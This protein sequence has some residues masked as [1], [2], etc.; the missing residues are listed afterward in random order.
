MIVLAFDTAM[1]GCSAALYD[2]EG[3]RVLAERHMVLPKGHADVIAPLIREIMEE[4]GVGFGNLGLIGVTIG[5]GTFTG[6]RTGLAMARGLGLSLA[7]PIAGID[8]LT[9]IACNAE[10]ELAPVAVAADARRG[11]VY[12]ALFG[13]DL[14]RLQEPAV[15]PVAEAARRLP[16]GP[17]NVIGSGAQALIAAAPTRQAVRSGA[18]DLPQAGTFIR[19]LARSE[20]ASTPPEPLYLRPPDARPQLR[21]GWLRQRW[22]IEQADVGTAGLIA[23]LH[24]ECFDNPWPAS[25]I[26]RL[27]AMP[28][29]VTLLAS[30]EGEPC[31]F[32]IGRQ[33]AGEAEILT[34]GTR[35]FARRQGAARALV[36]ELRNV[37]AAAGTDLL[38]IEVASNNEPAQ[39]LYSGLGFA[40]VGRRKH[41]YEKPGGP[42]E[43]AI[44]LRRN[45]IA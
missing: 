24:A 17:I 28:G 30:A 16:G 4:S 27:M 1:S 31:A 22:M 5:P 3:E 41:Y 42:S 39:R 26:A 13:R 43:D 6:L 33:A 36:E 18:G 14:S 19:R 8:T 9:A 34:L 12:Y 44:I 11:D 23:A 35:P 40:N 38:F 20:P 7:I 2:S 29:A 21:P 25:D 45:F 32:L 37:L 15:L 10:K